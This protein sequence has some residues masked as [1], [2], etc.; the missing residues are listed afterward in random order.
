MRFRIKRSG[1]SLKVRNNFAKIE[2]IDDDG[3]F[4][5][6]VD[7]YANVSNALFKDAITV[8]LT[9]Y[10]IDPRAQSSMLQG[11]KNSGDLTRNVLS[12]RSDKSSAIAQLKARAISSVNLDLSRG[13][14]NTMAPRLQKNSRSRPAAMPT[15][16]VLRAVPKSQIRRGRVKVSPHLGVSRQDKNFTSQNQSLKLSSLEAVLKDGVDPSS[17]GAR[18]F[19]LI[20]AK[21]SIQGTF[22]KKMKVSRTVGRA[23]KSPAAK[24]ILNNFQLG[25]R[26]PTQEL[27]DPR[28]DESSTTQTIPFNE[29]IKWKFY[30]N[31]IAVPDPTE[32]GST[33]LH[34]VFE[35]VDKRG[36]VV[37][38]LVRVADHALLLNSYYTPR[39]PPLIS[40]AKSHTLG[41]NILNIK[42]VDPVAV[43]V[44]VY[45][46]V[47]NPSAPQVTAGYSFITTVQTTATSGEIK[48]RDP[49]NNSLTTV[50]RAIPIGPGNRSSSRFSNYVA[51]AVK[52]PG[53]DCLPSKELEHASIFAQTIE[54]S[55]AVLVKVENIPDGP[56]SVYVKARDISIGERS[57]R[58]VGKDP[59]EQ[60]QTAATALVYTDM[61]VKHKHTY[62]YSCIMVYPNGREVVSKNPVTHEFQKDFKQEQ[63]KVSNSGPVIGTQDGDVVTTFDLKADFTTQGLNAVADSLKAAG[64][65]TKFNEELKENR[66]KYQALLAFEVL[67]EDSVTGEIESFGVVPA[68]TKFVDGPESR[69]KSGVKKMDPGRSYSYVFNLCAR[70]PGTFFTQT[71]QE[72]KDL[73]TNK[74][75]KENIFKYKNPFTLASG[76]LPSTQE[77]RGLSSVSGL[78][79][80][81]PILQA[82][83]GLSKSVSISLPASVA[84]VT[85]LRAVKID[86]DENLI[87]WTLKGS[88][89]RVDHFVVLAELEGVKS[90]LGT[91]HTQFKSNTFTFFDDE[92]AP[93]VG[94]TTYSIVPV[95]SDYSQ[96]TESEGV[97]V[98]HQ[99]E[100]PNF[101]SSNAAPRTWS[102]F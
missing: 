78:K 40:G 63:F 55:N 19:P 6:S 82:K 93:M 73:V 56:I 83:T 72:K 36:V 41:T 60:L 88:K 49:T 84:T 76:I 61:E 67:R 8:R 94:T 77:S 39:D 51:Q 2:G 18:K 34:F 98:T 70:D 10:P 37:D 47:I 38:Q 97:S 17:L 21:D 12:M 24:S 79:P 68:N 53:R 92:L 31:F 4:N 90:V 28:R 66:E 74:A 50:Y 7:Y 86:D 64:I 96:G 33:T 45:K 16:R 52:V 42:Q 3:L 87:T 58:I 46:K 43:A 5:Y 95:F 48:F 99:S 57:C 29:E 26:F 11:V 35:L 27:K 9:V 81:D 80:Q 71:S 75:Y 54:G 102:P 1:K 69:G 89:D 20:T 91:V 23:E 30:E 65:E 32:F 44:D 22:G 100:I 62:E 85:G 15:Q 59:G 25:G 14:S 13:I 101:A